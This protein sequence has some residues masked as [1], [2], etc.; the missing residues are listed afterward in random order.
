MIRR[1]THGDAEV[2][3]DVFLSARADALPEVPLVHS[4]SETRDYLLRLVT[5]PA[6]EVWVAERGGGVV[7][8]LSLREDWV[9][10]LYL[11]PGWYRQ[12]IG[13]ALLNVAKIGRPG[14][15]RLYCFQC[16]RRARAF[17]EAQGFFVVRVADGSDNEEHEPDIE[18]AWSAD[19]SA[20][21]SRP[22]SA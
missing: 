18:Y 3:A 10:H 19:A 4:E 16:N 5:N 20:A 7:G 12:D 13:T 22:G 8:F 11:R 15:L 9:D 17:Y 21:S 6:N 2:I 1:A 14:G